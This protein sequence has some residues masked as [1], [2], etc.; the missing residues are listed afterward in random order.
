MTKRRWWITLAGLAA[1]LAALNYAPAVWGSMFGEENATLIQILAE[2]IQMTEELQDLNDGMAVTAQVITDVRDTYN[3]VNAGIEEIKGYTF[4]SFLDDL[5]EDLYHQYPGFGELEGAS[6]K[7]RHWEDT[8]AR[9]PWTAYEA[10]TAV[11]G[12][13]TE[14]LREDA[15]AG[16]VN[17]DREYILAGEAAGG[18]SVAYTSEEATRAFDKETEALT[19]L[20]QNA[21]PGQSEQITARGIVLVAAQNSYIIRLL[22]RGVRLDGVNMALDYAARM[23]QRNAAYV[24]DQE[25]EDFF[26]TAFKPVPM[27]DF[28]ELE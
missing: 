23:D 1:G 17:L 21:S 24:F 8:R 27:A 5:K 16:R 12:D 19:L 25:A 13:L 11:A 14:P 4:D 18:F 26:G 10:I 3:Q 2:S 9:S 22:A 7:L 6:E 20:A 28:E 15:R